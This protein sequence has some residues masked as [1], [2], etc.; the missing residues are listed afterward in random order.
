MIGQCALCLEMGELQLSHYLPKSL[1]RIIVKGQSQNDKAPVV[2]DHANKTVMKHNRQI[3]KHLLCSDCEG[4]F[5]HCGE[6]I[7]IPQCAQANG[8]F[9]LKEILQSGEATQKIGG[10]AVYSPSLF[11]SQINASAYQY[12][13]ASIIWRGSVTHWPGLP[14]TYCNALGGKYQEAFRKYLL[15][16]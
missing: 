15:V 7:V 10:K 11:L 9:P 8:N 13:A 5:S 12:F 6:D 16:F 2:F 4:R 14:S 1:Y 3:T